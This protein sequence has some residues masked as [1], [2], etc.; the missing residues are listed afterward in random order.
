MGMTSHLQPPLALSAERKRTS[1]GKPF[2]GEL[3]SMQVR[4]EYCD[5]S[6]MCLLNYALSGVVFQTKHLAC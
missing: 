1:V 6:S 4:Y 3:P 5:A 2:H